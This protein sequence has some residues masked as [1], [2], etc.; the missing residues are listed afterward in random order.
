M[1]EG[2]ARKGA[3]VMSPVRRLWVILG[4]GSCFSTGALGQPE[5]GAVLEP[6]FGTQDQ[7]ITVVSGLNFSG[8]GGR[9]YVTFS[10]VFPGCLPPCP[11]VY[12]IHSTFSLP[13]GAVIES[14]GINST[15]DV[16][17]V[18]NFSLYSRDENGA[19]AD[20]GNYSIPVHPVFDTDYFD[21]N[22]P[23]PGNRGLTFVIV[24]R[25]ELSDDGDFTQR[26]GY[27]E[28]R[29]RRTVSSPPATPSFGDVPGSHPFFQFI[30]A[31]A[32]SGITGGCGGG[33]YCPEA[34]LT[35]G[36][37]AVFLSKALGLHWPR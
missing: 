8:A 18:M 29:W 17:A 7:T 34:A 13:A 4:I 12:Q 21:F 33:N 16:T 14:I 32:S 23:I 36:Q 20:L 31:L 5:S 15:S 28:V 6:K 10:Y 11:G 1:S 22:F 30:E 2:T 19:T 25:S 35:R 26:V 9:D 27:A 37:M 3:C 24:V